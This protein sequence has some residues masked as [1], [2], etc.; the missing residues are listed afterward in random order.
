MND[1]ETQWSNL[2]VPTAALHGFQIRS[3]SG[4]WLSLNNEGHRCVLVRNDTSKPAGTVLFE[5]KGVAASIEDLELADNPASPW[6]LVVCRDQR[7]WEPFSAFADALHEEIR[8]NREDNVSLTLRVLRTWKWLWTTDPEM[9]T[10]ESAVGLIGELWFLIRWAGITRA[11][12]AW[13]G[14]EGSIHDFAGH[15]VSVEVKATQSAALSGPTHHI[16]S[17]HQLMPPET[18]SLYLF[19][20]VI[21]PDN[22]AGNSLKRLVDI[23]LASLHDD[24]A[25]REQFLRKLSKIGWASSLSKQFD[26]PFRVLR[27]QL[28]EVNASFPALTQASFPNGLPSAVSAVT[29]SLDM[30][31]CD[32][33]SV[34]QT[35]EEGRRYVEGLAS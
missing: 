17:I 18:G 3:D 2:R 9:L 13:S 14:P 26:F 16:G 10:H 31:S 5:T 1:V 11:L 15:E 6:I 8:G 21:T 34:A 30:T 28:Y 22:S 23:G 4:I 7:Y 24:P 27:E 33:W 32:A 35:A 20:M 29:Y 12:D 19:S 25:R